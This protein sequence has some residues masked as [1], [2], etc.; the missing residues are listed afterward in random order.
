MPEN[1]RVSRLQPPGVFEAGSVLRCAPSRCARADGRMN[2]DR[3]GATLP[4]MKKHSQ[5]GLNQ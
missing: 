1:Y 2:A 4:A 5:P 3:F